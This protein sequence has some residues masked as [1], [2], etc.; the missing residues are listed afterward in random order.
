MKICSAALVISLISFLCGCTSPGRNASHVGTWNADIGEDYMLIWQIHATTLATTRDGHSQ[1]N[2]YTIDYSKD[3]IW[4]DSRN[5]SSDIHCIMEFLD[6]DSFRIV[7]AEN[8]EPRP[9]SF[10]GSKDIIVFKRVK[11]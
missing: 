6:S 1:T 2:S 10:A 3:P 11:Q 8:E 4:F 7:G 9:V 5:S